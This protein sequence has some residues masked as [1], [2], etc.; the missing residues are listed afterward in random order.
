MFAFHF[1]MTGPVE[2]D[3]LHYKSGYEITNNF[4]IRDMRNNLEIHFSKVCNETNM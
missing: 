1:K 2:I 4:N 3:E